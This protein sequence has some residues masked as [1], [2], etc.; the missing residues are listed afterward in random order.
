M[1]EGYLD[2]PDLTDE[3]IRE[4]WLYTGDIVER[5][6]DTFLIRGRVGDRINRGG[7]K[8]DPIDIEDVAAAVPGVTG[9]VACAI[10]HPVLGEDVALALE[11]REP[12]DVQAVREAVATI[13]ARNLP[14]FKVPRRIRAVREMPRGALGKPQRAVVAAWFVDVEIEEKV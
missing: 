1:M 11:V 10:P 6:E 2:R 4:G 14:A 13:L 8:F 5:R 9:A 12:H 7:Y 3:K